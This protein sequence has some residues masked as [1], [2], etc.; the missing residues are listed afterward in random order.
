[1]QYKSDVTDSGWADLPGDVNA[2]SSLAIKT[3]SAVSNAQ[4]YYRVLLLP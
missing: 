2:T 3:D 1:M 4:R